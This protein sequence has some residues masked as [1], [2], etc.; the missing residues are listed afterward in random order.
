M[1]C[2]EMTGIAIY[3]YRDEGADGATVDLDLDN[4]YILRYKAVSSLVHSGALRLI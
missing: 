3:G 1:W 4:Q 2:M